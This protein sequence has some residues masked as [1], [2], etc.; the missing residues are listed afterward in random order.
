MHVFI[1]AGL[2][3]CVKNPIHIFEVG[4]GTGLNALLT[5]IEAEKQHVHI[6]YQSIELFPIDQKLY[7]SLDYSSPLAMPKDLF[8]ALHTAPWNKKTEILPGFELKKTQADLLTAQLEDTFDVVYF[9]AFSPV[10]Q[11]GLWTEEIFD[12]IYNQMNEGGIL[13]TYC[14]KGIVRRTLEKTGFKTERLPGPPGKREMLRAIK[15]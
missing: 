15:R 13:T 7:Q 8:E 6:G 11:P 14:A 1:N 4:F 10:T 2:R 12:K 3:V 9:D 5:L